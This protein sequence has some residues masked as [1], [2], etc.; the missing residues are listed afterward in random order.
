[1]KQLTLSAKWVVQE[2]FREQVCDIHNAIKCVRGPSG[3]VFAEDIA[4]DA[5]TRETH[6]TPQQGGDSYTCYLC[7]GQMR[8]RKAHNRMLNGH[9]VS[10]R[11]HFF[12]YQE[13]AQTQ[14]RCNHTNESHEHAAAKE[15]MSHILRSSTVAENDIIMENDVV[16]NDMA[17]TVGSLFFF[18]CVNCGARVEITIS[19]GKCVQ[20]YALEQGKFRLDVAILDPNTN[21]LIGAIEVCQ[22]HPISAEKKEYLTTAGVAWVEI[23]ADNILHPVTD[24]A[25]GYLIMGCASMTC[26]AC[27]LAEQEAKK[28]IYALERRQ[29]EL[30]KEVE[31]RSRE[32]KELQDSLQTNTKACQDHIQELD[33]Q[34]ALVRSVSDTEMQ[35]LYQRTLERETELHRRLSRLDQD[36]DNEKSNLLGAGKYKNHRLVAVWSVDKKYVRSVA[37]YTGWLNEEKKKPNCL[38]STIPSR[39]W[40]SPELVMEARNR[41]KGHC[42]ICFVPVQ[43]EWR[44]YC[45]PC[46]KVAI[47]HT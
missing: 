12:H 36:P 38:P 29:V 21:R 20:E 33:R 16:C 27:L 37:G 3:P 31:T 24:V 7:G 26:V 45:N 18:L 19:K 32:W 17:F 34:L 10:V 46:F 47:D 30:Q 13:H 43:G 2:A 5:A 41:L 9:L 8:Y 14:H 42:L 39:Q 28:S 35:A 6:P 22:T 15:Y 44:T 4:F 25:R 40:L 23:H 1:M 11:A